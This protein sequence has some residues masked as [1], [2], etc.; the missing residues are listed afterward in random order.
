MYNDNDNRWCSCRLSHLIARRLQVLF[1]LFPDGVCMFCAGFLHFPTVQTHALR[2]TPELHVCCRQCWCYILTTA[3]FPALWVL[4]LFSDDYD[5]IQQLSEDFPPPP[6]EFRYLGYCYRTGR[7]ST[8]L[9]LSSCYS[10]CNLHC[11][12]NTFYEWWVNCFFPFFRID[13][14]VEK[15]LR[16]KFKVDFFFFFFTFF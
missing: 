13:P 14:K 15:E 7:K 10:S 3:Q 9:I 11:K 4:V 16:K 5:D 12:C 1:Q 6:P 8:A 2:Q